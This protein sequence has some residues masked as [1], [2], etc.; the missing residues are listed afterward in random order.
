M[1]HLRPARRLAL[2]SA[3]H[4]TV[5]RGLRMCCAGCPVG[6]WQSPILRGVFI[7]GLLGGIIAAMVCGPVAAGEE[8]ETNK[9]AMVVKESRGIRFVLPADWPL[10]EKDGVVGPIPV[11]DYVGRKFSA[12]E[13][14]ITDLEKRLEFLEKRL[15]AAE[16]ELRARHHVEQNQNQAGP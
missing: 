3:A 8:R 15:K 7:L 4:K 2:S 14:R 1:A 13:R 11:E 16:D 5:P 9:P 12:A 10:E 6:G